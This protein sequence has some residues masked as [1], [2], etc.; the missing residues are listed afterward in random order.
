MC[1]PSGAFSLGPIWY[2]INKIGPVANKNSLL[3]YY[4]LYFF[5][6]SA[7]PIFQPAAP[8]ERHMALEGTLNSCVSTNTRVYLLAYANCSRVSKPDWIKAV[9]IFCQQLGEYVISQFL[10][11]YHNYTITCVQNISYDTNG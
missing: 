9:W 11:V 2:F 6:N 4:F 3:P 1:V 10:R 8:I 7:G 5:I